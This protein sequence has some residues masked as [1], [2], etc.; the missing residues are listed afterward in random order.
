VLRPNIGFVGIDSTLISRKYSV[1]I[2]TVQNNPGIQAIFF[3]FDGV[4]LDS[5]DVKTRAFAEMFKQYGPE[6]EASVVAYHL[7]NG[8][9]SRF[10]K[11][12][13]YYSE[14]LKMP[15]SD[16]KLSE[17]GKKFSELVLA[18]VLDSNFIPGVKETLNQLLSLGIP[19]FVASGTPDEEIRYIVDKKGLNDFFR[20]IHGAPRSKTEIVRDILGR[21]GYDPWMCWFYGDSMSDWRAAV[22]SGVNFIGI[23]SD[24]GNSPFPSDTNVNL[25]VELP[26]GS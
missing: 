13:F 10:E 8:G 4:V 19:A 25:L 26:S 11:F 15:L 3:D 6:I 7:A 2:R 24:Y 18:E 12:R 1:I 23:V 21:F 22:E 14:L 17:L 5:V 9:I 16:K 20:E